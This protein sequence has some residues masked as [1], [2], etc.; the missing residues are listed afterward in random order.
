[1]IDTNVRSVFARA[2]NGAAQ[3]G[4]SLTRAEMD[5]ATALLPADAGV[6]RT[7]SVAV[8]E[9]GA[10]VCSARSPRCAECPVRDLCVWQRAG[11]PA[12]EG[13]ARRGQSWKGTD[14]QC[15]GAI[16]AVLRESKGPVT[17]STVVAAWSTDGPQRDRCLA[18]LVAD[19]L[20]EPLSDKRFRLPGR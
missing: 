1:M 9:V 12:Y 6:A 10:L 14:R 20:V 16:L 5:L 19:G 3:A 13:P 15:R 4:S 8:M 18:S 2:V 11:Q 17:A 7:R